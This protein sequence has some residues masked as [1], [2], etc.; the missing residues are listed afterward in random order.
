VLTLERQG[1]AAGFALAEW[2]LIGHKFPHP[3]LFNKF[4]K[5]A[6][7]LTHDVS[8]ACISRWQGGRALKT[9]LFS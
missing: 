5:L 6:E 7:Q 8:A 3:F 1:G 2:F 4:K 9:A